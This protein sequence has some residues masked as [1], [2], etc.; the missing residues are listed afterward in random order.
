MTPRE[1]AAYAQRLQRTVRHAAEVGLA[2]AAELIAKD[3]RDRL[4][5]YQEN[6]PSLAEATIL[7]KQRQGYEV[8]SP[9][10][11]TGELRDSIRVEQEGLIALIGS[12]HPAAKVHEHGDEHVPPRP[13]LQPALY[14]KAPEAKAIIERTVAAAIRNVK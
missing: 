9:L 7:E 11:R 5:T 1:F 13:F 12:D 4:G 8:P 6:W 2:E 10:K 14:T 3:A